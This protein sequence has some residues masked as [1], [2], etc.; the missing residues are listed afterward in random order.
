[1][2]NNIIQIYS[3]SWLTEE[4]WNKNNKEL[5][6]YSIFFLSVIHAFRLGGASQEPRHHLENPFQLFPSRQMNLMLLVLHHE[7]ERESLEL[8]LERN[9]RTMQYIYNLA[10]L[11]ML[12]TS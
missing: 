9:I 3:F 2:D 5:V 12:E 7:R 10:K 1:M 8:I 6:T 11:N 4:E